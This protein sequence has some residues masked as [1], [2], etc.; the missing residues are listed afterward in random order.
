MDTDEVTEITLTMK[1]EHNFF[2]LAKVYEIDWNK[3]PVEKEQIML[4]AYSVI[5]KEELKK[6]T[7]YVRFDGVLH[8]SG[9]EYYVRDNAVIF[10]AVMK[11]GTINKVMHVSYTI[12]ENMIKNGHVRLANKAAQAKYALTLP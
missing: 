6:L 10:A 2:K 12:I 7:K 1:P 3:Y 4:P 11:D 5:T 8:I 9:P